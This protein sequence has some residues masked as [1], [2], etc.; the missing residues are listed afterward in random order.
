M[1]ISKIQREIWRVLLQ[2]VSFYPFLFTERFCG[3]VKL[4]WNM[5]QYKEGKNLPRQEAFS[6]VPGVA[7]LD[8]SLTSGFGEAV[9]PNVIYIPG[10]FR[11]KWRYLMTITPFPKGIVYFENPEFLVSHDGI[12]WMIPTGGKSPLVNPPT[13]WIG[14]NSD[15]VLCHTDDILYLLYREVRDQANKVVTSIFIRSTKDGIAWNPPINVCTKKTDRDNAACLMSPSIQLINGMYHIWY[16]EKYK[17]Q[18]IIRH[19]KCSD[20]SACRYEGEIVELAEMP[21]NLAVWHIEVVPDNNRLI[22][23]LCAR[24]KNDITVHSILFA[25]SYDYGLK[26]RIFGEQIDPVTA[27]GEKSLYKASL[28]QDE[29][30]WKLYYSCLDMG[31][32]W[33][34]V[35]RNIH[36]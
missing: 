27:N 13:D 1:N 3:R 22:M 23:A 21:D 25:E 33:F 14:Y 11:G 34:P 12:N 19:T 17:N 16:V 5:L 36:L 32:H 9:H 29:N 31:G 18:L 2:A 28:V 4:K 15:P 35:V 30:G 8:L 10:G 26:W 24:N 7:A 20:L 6:E